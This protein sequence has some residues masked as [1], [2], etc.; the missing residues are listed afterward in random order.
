MS[1]EDISRPE[2]HEGKK[3]QCPQGKILWKKQ[4][5]LLEEGKT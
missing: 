3:I 4:V 5:A 2:L 1:Q